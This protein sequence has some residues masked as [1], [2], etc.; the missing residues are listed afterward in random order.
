MNLAEEICRAASNKNANDIM[1]LDI[2]EMTVVADKFIICSA[3]SKS[4]VKAICDN[5][6]EQLLKKG[7]KASK[8]DGY[9][10]ARWIVL[11]YGDVMAHIFYDEDR[12]FYNLERLWNNGNNMYIYKDGQENP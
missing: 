2:S 7:V 5:I 12:L 8:T 11:D 4:Q 3:P 9:N 6:E 1:V 10:E